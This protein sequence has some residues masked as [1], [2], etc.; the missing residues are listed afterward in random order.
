MASLTTSVEPLDDNKV[1]VS[2]TVPAAEFE[3]AVDAA[4]RKLA[5]EVKVPGFRPGKAPR[6]LLEARFGS[7][8]AREQALRDALP[9]YYEQAIVAESVDAIAVPE[10]DITAGEEAG[11]VTFDAVVEVRPVVTVVGY[12]GLRVEVPSPAVGE[13]AVDAQVDALR[14]RFAD[15]ADSDD[16]LIDGNFALVDVTSTAGDEVVD[17]L[18]ATDFLYEVGSAMLVEELD[19]QLR[20]TQPGAIL[21]FDAELPERFGERAGETISFQVVVKETKRKVLPDVDDEWASEVSEF[22]TVAE[23]RAD[24]AN[25]LGLMAKVQ[26]QMLVRDKVLEAAADLVT[27]DVPDALVES[28]MERRLHDLAHRLEHQGMTIPQYLMM[29]GQEQGPFVDELR[30]GCTKAVRADLALRS[31]VHQEAITADDDE[32]DAE[33]ERLAARLEQKPAKVRRDLE[34]NGAIEALRS[35]LARG[36]AVRFLVD[37]ADVVDEDGN[38]VDLSLPEPDADDGSSGPGSTDTSDAEETD[39]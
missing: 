30:E 38:P 17:A 34:R 1:R 18:S 6:R 19:A 9:D 37:H 10:I 5:A 16:P 21:K 7:E 39:E 36:K 2:V 33:V 14:E 26:A 12:D 25:R 28:E 15:L 27:V 31:V 3:K 20:G 32:V 29:T 4:F 23:L 8:Y 22:D 13:E 35:D 11:D 24:V